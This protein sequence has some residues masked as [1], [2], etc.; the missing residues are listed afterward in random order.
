MPRLIC[1]IFVADL[2][3]CRL[4]YFMGA[5]VCKPVTPRLWVGFF[6]GC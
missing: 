5:V 6:Y 3:A 4:S 1:L 2:I